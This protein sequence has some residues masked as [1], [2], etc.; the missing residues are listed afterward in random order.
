MIKFK[1]SFI[2]VLALLILAHYFYG[3]EII[4]SLLLVFL[5]ILFI[6]FISMLFLKKYIE[7]NLCLESK[8]FFVDEQSKIYLHVKNRGLFF[9]PDIGFLFD[10]FN[11]REKSSGSFILPPFKELKIELNCE[12]TDRGIYSL[13]NCFLEVGDIFLVSSTKMN[14]SNEHDIIVYPKRVKLPLKIE[15]IIDR[16]SEYSKNNMNFYTSDTYSSIDKY[17]AGD[18]FKDIHWKLSAKMNELYV[19]KFDTVKKQGIEIYV[20][21][22]DCL[23]QPKAFHNMTDENLVSFSLSIIKY[24]LWKGETIYVNIENL[25]SSVFKLDKIDDYYSILSYYLKHKSMGKNDFFNKVLGKKMQ[26]AEVYR[27]T[28][29]ITYTILS[30]NVEVLSKIK[31]NCEVLIVFVLVDISYKIKELL[32]HSGIDVVVLTV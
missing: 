9:Y 8:K 26:N 22:T 14:F 11:V 24:L 18:N 16:A 25:Q 1:I 20:D 12:F 4:N 19:K 10:F 32:S 28:Y 13:K 2:A 30:H 23:M 17:A 15:R 27:C 31:N 7:I 29:I 6:S 5:S 3:K 21:M